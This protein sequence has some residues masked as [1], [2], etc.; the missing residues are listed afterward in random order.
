[1]TTC[2][3]YMYPPKIVQIGSGHRD[4]F[5]V[6]KKI[7]HYFWR[8]VYIS[9]KIEKV[10]YFEPFLVLTTTALFCPLQ[11]F[12]ATGGAEN[13]YPNTPWCRF[14]VFYDK[15]TQC[16]PSR[17]VSVSYSF[18]KLIV[19]CK[20]CAIYGPMFIG[21]HG[22]YVSWFLKKALKVINHSLTHPEQETFLCTTFWT[23]YRW[24]SC[25]KKCVLCVIINLKTNTAYRMKT[26][27]NNSM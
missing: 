13:S 4:N 16:V 24:C 9:G 18:F 6:W 17:F 1:M 10:S 14:A 22:W 2:M 25:D 26:I 19:T 11:R 7:S 8:T 3:H 27:C 20:L 21:I 15:S 5:C 23:P 12:G